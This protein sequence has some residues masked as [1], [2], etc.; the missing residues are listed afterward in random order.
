MQRKIDL[1]KP[2]EQTVQRK[3]KVKLKVKRKGKRK[4]KAIPW[5]KVKA[6]L[7]SFK[8]D[9][10]NV[11]LNT[12]DMPLNGILFPVVYLIAFLTGKNIRI[13]FLDETSVELKIRNSL[14]GMSWAFLKS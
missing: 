7:Q 8:W 2:K 1:L 3:K 6:V 14:A 5:S 4:G 12:G 9:K 11:S 13:N 10:C